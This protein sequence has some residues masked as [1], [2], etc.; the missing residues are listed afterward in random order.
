MLP[1]LYLAIG[2]PIN[3]ALAQLTEDPAA[4]PWPDL[5]QVGPHRAVVVN[6]TFNTPTDVVVDDA[7]VSNTRAKSWLGAP[8]LILLELLDANENLIA[9]QNA[10]HPLWVRDLNE[11]SGESTPENESGP[12]TFYVAFDE[13]LRSIRITDL[14]LGVELITVD[15]SA[16]VEAY[17]AQMPN[18]ALCS[19]M[20]SGFE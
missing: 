7:V 13:D 19:I 20:K 3:V 17:C 10:W 4:L 6:V 2:A 18:P 14:E 8:P 11:G 1:L 5:T 9:T 12:G 16:V 15:V